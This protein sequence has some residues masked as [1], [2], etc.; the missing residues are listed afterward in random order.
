V[1]GSMGRP[2]SQ[3]AA[4]TASCGHTSWITTRVWAV[5]VEEV[6]VWTAEGGSMAA[7]EL[8]VEVLD[9]HGAPLHQVEHGGQIYVVA[10]PGPYTVRARHNHGRKMQVH[11]TVDGKSCG[12]N[13][14]SDKTL[15]DRSRVL[16]MLLLMVLL[17]RARGVCSGR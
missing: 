8:E 10:R 13:R 4:P 11:V 16:M 9:S 15:L 3:E 2:R 5:W 12:E 1:K 14:V 7:L 17:T 6:R